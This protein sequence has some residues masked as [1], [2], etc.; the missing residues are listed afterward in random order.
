M[1]EFDT[2]SFGRL[3]QRHSLLLLDDQF[4]LDVV[5]EEV[6]DDGRDAEQRDA[7]IKS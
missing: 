2:F 3:L 1:L 4:F 6:A 5:E 7:W